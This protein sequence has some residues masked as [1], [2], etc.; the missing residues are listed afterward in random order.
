[1]WNPTDA[2]GPDHWQAI[3][4]VLLA[5]IAWIPEVQA[6]VLHFLFGPPGWTAAPKVV[7][8]LLPAL[9]LLWALWCTAASLYTLV[10]RSQRRRFCAA[11]LMAWW[12]SARAVWCYWIGLVRFAY[13]AGAWGLTLA[14]LAVRL[15]WEGVRLLV[16]LPVVQASRLA[17]RYLRPGMPWIAA[18]LLV[19]WAALEASLFTY[20]SFPAVRDVLETSVGVRPPDATGPV[21]YGMLLLLLLGGFACLDAVRDA[22]AAR[23]AGTIAAR[24]GVLVLIAGFEVGL[25][26]RQAVEVAAPGVAAR[27]G[28]ALGLPAT[29]VTA[30][31]LW[32]AV[33]GATWSLFGR[34]GARCLASFVSRTRAGEASEPPMR[35]AVGERRVVPALPA[36]DVR[37]EIVWLRSKAREEIEHL[38]LPVLQ[39]LAAALNHAVVVLASR[40]A[41][42]LPLRRVDDLAA[43]RELLAALHG[44]PA[45]PGTSAAAGRETGPTVPPASAIGGGY[46]RGTG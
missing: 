6:S 23:K 28:I 46:R 2:G 40:P 37:A 26:Y 22:V 5:P 12:D 16:A 31:L 18:V 29:L 9:L 32:L 42:D 35:P 19:L 27:T 30:A 45:S 14:R 36:Q 33:R 17:G 21:L 20:L 13:V 41:F 38:T 24:T 10:F 1:M 11:T 39:L 25:L 44:R 34:S 15:A 8:L 4:F 7:F 43:G 3:L